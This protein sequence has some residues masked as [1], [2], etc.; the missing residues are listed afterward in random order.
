M[1]LLR[2]SERWQCFFTMLGAAP[3]APAL[4]LGCAV[5]SG[6]DGGGGSSFL[7]FGR[8]AHAG[9]GGL[10]ALGV[11]G[12]WCLGTC[13]FRGWLGVCG[14][15]ECFPAPAANPAAHLLRLPAAE[16]LQCK[17]KPNAIPHRAA[18][19]RVC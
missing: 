4:R 16:A 1:H 9:I 5:D 3:P 11:T 10:G 8:A 7:P 14:I 19:A 15:G 2:T 18:D 6:G 12:R 13:R 17:S